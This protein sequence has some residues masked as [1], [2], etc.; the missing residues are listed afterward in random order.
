MLILNM[1]CCETRCRRRMGTS[2]P[3]GSQYFIHS[4]EEVLA[5]LA[6]CPSHRL[7]K[8]TGIFNCSFFIT[9]IIVMVRL[10]I[11]VRSLIHSSILSCLPLL[12]VFPVLF[13]CFLS[14][15]HSLPFWPLHGALSFSKF[16]TICSDL[17]SF[18]SYGRTFEICLFWNPLVINL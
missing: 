17:S 6:E 1:F 10:Q 18:T 2:T 4:R 16:F 5:L 14:L 11:N 13:T 12:S 9:Y 7:V 8:R 15:I 3:S